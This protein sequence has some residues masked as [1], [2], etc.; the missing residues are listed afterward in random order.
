MFNSTSISNLQTQ[1]LCSLE[2]CHQMTSLCLA[3]VGVCITVYCVCV[4]GGG[5]GWGCGWVCVCVCV[6]C[7]LKLR[8]KLV[9][10]QIKSLNKCS[11]RYPQ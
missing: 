3:L 2:F 10:Q 11:N 4:W 1:V 7:L 9:S 8:S 6:H 5:G